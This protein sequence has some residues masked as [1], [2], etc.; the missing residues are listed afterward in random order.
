M[1]SNG[2]PEVVN[3]VASSQ[4][5]NMRQAFSLANKVLKEVSYKK[6]WPILIREHAFTTVADQV[7]YPLPADFHHLVTP[8]AVDAGQYYQLKG[9]LTP[10]QW[11]RMSLK[12]AVEWASGFRIDPYTK[13]FNV[14]PTPSDGRDLVFMYVTT[15]I[16]MNNTGSPVSRY[17]QDSDI[18]LVEEELV[19]LG[20][21]WRWRQ[22]KGLDYTAEMAE[23][24]GTL[25]A[26]F[27]Q[28]LGLGDLSVG[29]YRYSAEWPL[30]DGY[31][32]VNKPI[33]V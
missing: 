11:F 13:T 5:Q 17:T 22:K 16:A 30:T 27:A 33:G 12:G 7:S 28:Q 8:S 9:S 2:W 19:E 31:F 1:D 3:S 26:R 32:D 15:D 23:Y 20:L 4:D 10:I 6:N 24:N 14:A 21:S 18:S 25:A 29:G